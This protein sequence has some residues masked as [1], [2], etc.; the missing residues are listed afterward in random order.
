VW[1]AHWDGWKVTRYDPTGKVEREV[2]LPVQ[3]VT[4]CAFGGEN[5]DDL[6]ITTAWENL[7]EEEREKQPLAGDL[8][9]INVQVQGMAEP[10]FAG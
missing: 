6:Y 8:F 1:S 4:S 3:K 2:G 5:L 10:S 9:C 7:S